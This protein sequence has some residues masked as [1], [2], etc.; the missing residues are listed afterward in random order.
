V[1]KRA[2]GRWLLRMVG[3]MTL[4]RRYSINIRDGLP[5]NTRMQE[6]PFSGLFRIGGVFHSPA[7]TESTDYQTLANFRESRNRFIKTS[8]SLPFEIKLEFECENES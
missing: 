4:R 1:S 3:H 2:L 7:L 8:E 5:I 6:M